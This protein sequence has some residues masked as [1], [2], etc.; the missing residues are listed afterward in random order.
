MRRVIAV[1]VV[2]GLVL[3]VGVIS[4]T[5][6]D[7]F[8]PVDQP[9]VTA[10]EIKVGGVASTTNP[11]GGKYADAFN[12]AQAYFDYVN[13]K[14]G[15]Y[16]RDL[17][18]TSEHDDQLANNRQEIQSLLEEDIFAVLP[19]SVLLFTGAD[20]LANSG[21]P[22]FGWNINAEWGS[23]KAAG[24]PNFF[25]EKGSYLD[26]TGPSV[27]LPFL[28]KKLKAKNVAVLGYTVEQS[29]DCV[30]GVEA[31]F[32]KYPT[33]KVVF[34]DS[35]LSFGV[36]DLSSDVSQMIDKKVDLVTTCMDNNGVLTLAREMKK[37]GL[38][39]AQSLPNA[40]DHA[41]IEENAQFFN[42]SYV[43]T[44]FTPFEVKPK[45]PGLKNFL[46][47]IK[48]NGDE[49]NENSL[50]GWING[51]LLFTGL[52]AAGP[53]FTQQKVIDA[54]NKITDYTAGGIV[55]PI[56]W[57]KQHAGDPDK[58]CTVESKVVD[59]KFV[60]TFGKPGKPF[61]CFPRDPAKLPTPSNL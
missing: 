47:W 46:K 59:G 19:V 26:F 33:A 61:I 6:Q 9:G 16:G 38:D 58:T 30:D 37:Q 13:S 60:P 32:K 17:K 36:T 48:K 45:P 53:D 41:F 43:L 39:A 23:E 7:T 3:G 52:K 54:I 25:G 31:S 56:D 22:T 18:L 55:G 49:A 29:K 8:P 51:D 10:T 44:F 27:G 50:S 12:G 20:L 57:T 15:I 2:V 34:N 42:N 4:A 21:I 14:G 1:L 5:A 28:A 11:L 40:Y 35:S 24:P